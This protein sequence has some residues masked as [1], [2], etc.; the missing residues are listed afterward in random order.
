LLDEL[1]DATDLSKATTAIFTLSAT[2]KMA[3]AGEFCDSLIKRVVETLSAEF[4]KLRTFAT[5][6]PIPGLRTWLAQNADACWH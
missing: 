3:C 1:A 4:P 6:S 2:R 5:L